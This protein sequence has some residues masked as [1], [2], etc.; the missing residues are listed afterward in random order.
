VFLDG[1]Q[2]GQGNA[3]GNAPKTPGIIGP[4][5]I[6]GWYDDDPSR[7]FHGAI[8]ELRIYNRVLADQEILLLAQ[9]PQ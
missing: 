2:T 3:A 1:S 9:P 6:G 8:D 4:A 5:R 7:A